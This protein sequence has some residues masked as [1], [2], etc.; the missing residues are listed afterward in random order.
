M[1]FFKSGTI[2]LAAAMIGNLSNYFFQFF[3]SRNFSIEDYGA[4]NAIFS[5]M[6][7]TGIPTGTIMLVV[8][9]YTSTF[10]AGSKDK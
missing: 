4:M 1:S 10:K 5:L 3:M 9:K 8:A 7:I 2:L 6:A